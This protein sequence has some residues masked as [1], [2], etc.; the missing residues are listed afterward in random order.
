VYRHTREEA[1]AAAVVEMQVGVDDAGDVA[2]GM[3]TGCGVGPM[4]SIS[5][6]ES[7]SPVSTSTSPAG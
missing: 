7:I 4:S 2:R 1:V 5:G 6:L 3:F